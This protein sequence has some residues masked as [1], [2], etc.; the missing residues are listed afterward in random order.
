MGALRRCE[1]EPE[2]RGGAGSGGEAHDMA[3]VHYVLV[4]PSENITQKTVQVMGIATTGQ[5]GPCEALLQLKAK[6]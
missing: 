2:A 5:W 4:H 6:R 3:E 1:T